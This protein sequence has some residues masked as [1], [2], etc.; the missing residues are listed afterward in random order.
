VVGRNVKKCAGCHREVGA[1]AHPLCETCYR[2]TNPL[3]VDLKR[4]MME[5][6]N[7]LVLERR[8]DPAAVAMLNLRPVD[9][10]EKSTFV[11]ALFTEFVNQ[12]PDAQEALKELGFE[13]SM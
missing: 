7:K 2:K 6:G 1:N 11:V 3:P 8:H 10:Q 5:L 12:N 4:V 13:W 9:L